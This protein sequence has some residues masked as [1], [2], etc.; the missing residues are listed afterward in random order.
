MKVVETYSSPEYNS[1]DVFNCNNVLVAYY[2]EYFRS[3]IDNELLDH[4]IFE[5]YYDFDDVNDSSSSTSIDVF[6]EYE[7][8]R[9]TLEDIVERSHYIS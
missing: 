5:C 6:D 3:P 9:T 2:Y 8:L 4:V 7:D 1:F